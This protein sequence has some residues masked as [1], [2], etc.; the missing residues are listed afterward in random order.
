MEKGVRGGGRPSLTG[1]PSCH[2]PHGLSPRPAWLAQAFQTPLPPPSVRL[3][4]ALS[5]LHPTPPRRPLHPTSPPHFLPLPRPLGLRAKAA[6]FSGS[7]SVFLCD[8]QIPVIRAVRLCSDTQCCLAREFP[9]AVV[10]KYH[11][12]T[13][14]CRLTVLGARSLRSGRQ[15]DWFYSGPHLFQDSFLAPGSSPAIFAIP[16]LIDAS[17][18]SL[19]SCSHV[20]PVSLRMV[21]CAS[22]SVSKFPFL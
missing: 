13:E 7:R 4:C 15:E 12:T 19:P 14:M 17:P 18:L 16:C 6:S 3:C 22:V 9:R 1:A 2:Q 8:R 21:F 20:L 5:P 11:K 10:T